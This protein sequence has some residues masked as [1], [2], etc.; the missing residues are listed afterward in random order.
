LEKSS[1]EVV[2]LVKPSQLLSPMSSGSIGGANKKRDSDLIRE[3]KGIGNN[4][5]KIES[6]Y[7]VV[8]TQDEGLKAVQTGGHGGANDDKFIVKKITASEFLGSFLTEKSNGGGGQI[9][10]EESK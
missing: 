2:A 1:Q 4:E 8:H 9:E 5:C 7:Q 6:N 10:E 3:F